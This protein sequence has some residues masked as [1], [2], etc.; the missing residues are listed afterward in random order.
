M[1]RQKTDWKK[2]I[3]KCV[4]DGELYQEYIQNSYSPG[5]KRRKPNKMGKIRVCPRNGRAAEGCINMP[6]VDTSPTNGC[7]EVLGHARPLCGEKKFRTERGSGPGS[8]RA[9]DFWSYVVFCVFPGFGPQADAFIATHI[10]HTRNSPI[11]LQANF[12]F[13]TSVTNTKL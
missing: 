1:K 9:G 12:T 13:K 11:S 3:V 6:T 10:G 7:R 4:A 5:I 2:K 8:G